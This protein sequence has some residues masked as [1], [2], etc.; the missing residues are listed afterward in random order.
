MSREQLVSAYLE[1]QLDRRAFVRRLI[2][3]G[4]SV[5]AAMTYADRLAPDGHAAPMAWSPSDHY[6]YTRLKIVSPNLTAVEVRRKLKVKVASSVDVNLDLTAYFKDTGG[7]M[8]R[9]GQASRSASDGDVVSIPVDP[10]PL[11]SATSARFYVA[12]LVS[13]GAGALYASTARKLS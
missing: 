2:A 6:P 8:T 1:G 10:M 3:A 5:G 13:G 7:G 11:G 9:L 12:A 4:I